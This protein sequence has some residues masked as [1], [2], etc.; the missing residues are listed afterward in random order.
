M[1]LKE[2]ENLKMKIPNNNRQYK[3]LPLDYNEKKGFSTISKFIFV[4]LFSLIIV[5]FFI[6]SLY[7]SNQQ[8]KK[9]YYLENQL[10]MRKTKK[11]FMKN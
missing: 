10:I 6:I 11:F 4:L 2:D 9:P 8:Q 5:S 3:Y 7:F 1:K